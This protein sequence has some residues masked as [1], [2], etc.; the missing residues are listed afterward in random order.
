MSAAFKVPEGF[1]VQQF[2]TDQQAPNI[3][4]MT[5]D[6]RGRVIVAGPGY[7]RALVDENKD[8]VADR[9]IVLA[10]NPK[11]GAQGLAVDG[12]NLLVVGDGGL[13]LWEGLL[14]VKGS[15]KPAKQLLHIP[16][17]SEHGTHSIQLGP[18]H[19]WYVIAG[20]YAGGINALS[21]STG[22]RP[23][24]A[25]T[26]WRIEKN[27]SKKQLW[28]EGIRNAYDFSF[29]A[30]GNIVT[31]D[32]DDERDSGLPFYRPCRVLEL[33]VDSDAGWVSKGWKDGD[34]YWTMP[35]ILAE[36]GRAS[37]TGVTCCL[38]PAWPSSY[39]GAIIVADWTFGRI[40]CLKR[41]PNGQWEKELLLESTGSLGFA[42]P[43][44]LLTSMDDCWFVPAVAARKGCL[45]LEVERGSYDTS[46]RSR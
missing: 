11:D 28:S 34:A 17:G 27:F 40:W 16:T 22:R 41:L 44:W 35:G 14:S 19:H 26:I 24:R 4:N 3:I 8:G 20:N 7:V 10:N 6:S 31:Y 5:V 21:E 13:W 2:S 46:R 1:E 15:S 23:A 18:D 37:P 43:T 32:S 33:N 36:T 39:Y 42:R 9:S 38:H 25:G 29:S 12:E 45:C 30:L